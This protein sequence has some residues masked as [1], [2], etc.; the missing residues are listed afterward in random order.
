MAPKPAPVESLPTSDR[1]GQA[2]SRQG[3]QLCST[4]SHGEPATGRF[5][6][7]PAERATHLRQVDRAV[8]E[9]ASRCRDGAGGHGGQRRLVDLQH[10]F[11]TGEAA[12]EVGQHL[13]DRVGDRLREVATGADV[14]EDASDV[15]DAGGC[16]EG[17]GAG[18]GHLEPPG[19]AV[20][21]LV[22]PVEVVAPGGAGTSLVDAGQAGQPPLPGGELRRQ[23][24]RQAEAASDH[25]G[26]RAA[27]G[28]FRQVRQA[29]PCRRSGA[30][31][32]RNRCRAGTRRR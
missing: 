16:C 6:R 19:V 25:L 2:P 24:G 26:P 17:P 1:S 9:E 32:R 30:L 3:A 21:D 13:A 4:V 12:G 5:G 18:D 22:E 10:Q 20:C 31:R 15:G 23:A 8:A 27:G 14:G 28:Q 7:D 29:R 11:D